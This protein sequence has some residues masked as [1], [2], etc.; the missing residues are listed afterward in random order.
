M[1]CIVINLNLQTK[2]KSKHSFFQVLLKVRQVF[3]QS[4][5]LLLFGLRCL[6]QLACFFFCLSL[7][8]TSVDCSLRPP[9]SSRTKN[10]STFTCPFRRSLTKRNML[11]RL[12]ALNSITN[13]HNTTS[14]RNAVLVCHRPN[15]QPFLTTQ[16]LSIKALTSQKKAK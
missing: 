4:L 11:A 16:P 6:P 13:A 14:Y 7:N 10:F 8:D 3:A 12:S 2:S 5:T 1:Q 15:A 9:N